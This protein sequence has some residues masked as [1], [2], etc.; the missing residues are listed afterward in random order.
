MLRSF[1]TAVTT[2]CLGLT[3]GSALA[4]GI[5]LPKTVRPSMGG[6]FIVNPVFS[7]NNA[8]QG[9]SYN[10]FS[11]N[12]NGS[13]GDAL[14]GV[15]LRP[16]TVNTQP[17]EKRRVLMIVPQG[18]IKSERMLAVCMWK[19]PTLP[20]PGGRSQLLAAFRYCRLFTAR[21]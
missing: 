20:G 18:A 16:N 5:E 19:D 13:L 15:V 1:T 7:T 17:G 11:V 6:D 4:E 9:L 3:S 10:I 21:P 2:L 14:E 12:P 8:V